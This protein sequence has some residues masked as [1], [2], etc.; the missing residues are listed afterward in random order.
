MASLLSEIVEN[1]IKGFLL[2][3][4][5][6]LRTDKHSLYKSKLASSNSGK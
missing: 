3:F 6:N 4:A 5:V 2:L 1:N